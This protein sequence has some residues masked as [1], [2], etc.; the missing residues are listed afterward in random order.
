MPWRIVLVFVCET[1]AHWNYDIIYG[2]IADDTIAKQMRR[3]DLE[4]I[5]EEHFMKEIQYKEETFQYFFGTGKAINHL[6]KTRI[7]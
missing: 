4:Y 5:D 6:I 7:I 2:P 1:E 3:L